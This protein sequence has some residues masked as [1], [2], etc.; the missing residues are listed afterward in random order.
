MT[1]MSL[2]YELRRPGKHRCP[3]CSDQ[4]RNKRERC[5]S[6][7][8]V[9]GAW[10]WYCHN[11]CGFSGAS[12]RSTGVVRAPRSRPGLAVK[13]GIETKREGGA[14]WIAAPY[15][16]RGRTINHKYRLASEKRHRMDDGAPLCLWNH[17]ALLETG[18]APLIVTEGEWDAMAAMQA[19]FSRCVSVPNGAPQQRTESLEEAK[20]YEFLWRSKD[21]LDR[22]KTIIIATDA[23]EP[24]R[25]LAADL[26]RWFGPERCRFIEYPE[27]T[28]DLNEVLLRSGE[29]GVPN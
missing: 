20:R 16:E 19:G 3:Q 10:L 14:N 11:G 29:S 15:V 4:R 28:K 17:D 25:I 22:V 23:D 18:N 2:P 24:G 12:F 13:L 1:P 27:G 7:D 8:L 21:L 9:D 5:L 6:V 26:A